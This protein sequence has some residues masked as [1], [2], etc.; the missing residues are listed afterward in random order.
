MT[1]EQSYLDHYKRIW[2]WSWT[3][4]VDHQQGAWFRIRNRDGSAFDDLK[5][6]PGKT[7]YHTLGACWDVLD[8]M[9]TR[10]DLRK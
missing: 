4:L 10:G 1:G 5:S 9:V 3:H 7:D 2:Q 6:P 8:A